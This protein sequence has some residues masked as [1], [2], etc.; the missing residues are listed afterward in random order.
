MILPIELII[1]IDEFCINPNILK[2]NK[3]INK[4]IRQSNNSIHWKSKYL[5]KI[6]ELNISQF[7]LDINQVNFNSKYEY[8]R[9]LKQTS[10]IKNMYARSI[11][12]PSF[13]YYFIDGLDIQN[14]EDWYIEIDFPECAFNMN[15]F[16][17]PKEFNKFNIRICTRHT[18]SSCNECRKKSFREALEEHSKYVINCVDVD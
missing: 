10:I 18:K 11:L 6:N 4:E 12:C 16:K 9:L 8:N 14:F 3:L 15:K 5:E 7:K 17:I 2:L 13:R 1:Y